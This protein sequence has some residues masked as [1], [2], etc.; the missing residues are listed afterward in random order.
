MKHPYHPYTIAL[1]DCLPQGKRAEELHTIP[2]S[3][4]DLID[5]PLGCRFHPRCPRV[6]D[7]C[8]TVKPEPTAISE[9]TGS[10]CHYVASQRALQQGAT[11][12][13]CPS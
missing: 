10:A 8:V 7:V 3:V 13:P 11:E 6:M 1:Y 5:P 12:V 2:G 4:P 9:S